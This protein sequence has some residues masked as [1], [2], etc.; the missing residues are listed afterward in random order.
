MTHSTEAVAGTDESM[1]HPVVGAGENIAQP[2][3]GA[4]GKVI[5]GLFGFDWL[6]RDPEYE[7]EIML[8][9]P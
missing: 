8:L 1:S 3:I 2:V 7:K 6:E 5:P 9:F 4:D